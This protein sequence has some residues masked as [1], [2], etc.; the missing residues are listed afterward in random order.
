MSL[1]RLH[2]ISRSFGRVPVLRKVF[3]R[4]SKGDRVGLIGK[5]GVG[6]TTLLRLILGQD[7]PDGGTVDI[8]KGLTI[9]YFSQFSELSDSAT[10][11]DILEGLFSDIHLIKEEL[12]TIEKALSDAPAEKQIGGLLKRQ[13]SLFETMER[14]EGWTYRNRIDTVLT[15]LGFSAA[16]RIKPVGQLSGGWRNRAALAKILLEAPDILLM[17]EPTNFLDTDGLAWLEKWL[18][19]IP[20]ALIVVSH[21]R[22]FLDNV[23]GRIIEIENHQFQEYKGNF[24]QYIREKKLRLKTLGRQ[25]VFEKEL[26]IFEEAAIA[27]RREA[28]QN[29]D[30]ALKRKLANVKKQIEPKPSDRIITTI[31]D[32]L[33]VANKLCTVDNISKSH[34]GQT[35]FESLSFMIHRGDR[36][37]VIGP[38]GCGK[39]TL[40]RVLTE[41]HTPDTGS[42]TWHRGDGYAYYNRILDTLDLDDT[43]T[44]AVNVPGLG[45]R[46]P[47]KHVNR[48]LS[49]F[50]FSEMDLKQRIGALSGGQCARVALAISLLSGAG[51]IILDEPTNHLDITS[52]QVM[53]RALI[54]FPGAVLVVSHDRFFIDK[55][56]TRL[57]VFTD[58]GKVEEVSGNWTMWQASMETAD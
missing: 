51:V 47:R 10:I 34:P 17:D 57:L 42:V 8:D 24:T 45:Y 49:L 21:D 40:I 35:I 32:R 37:A 2:N 14:L 28:A 30:K 43:V 39:T 4:L 36:I 16:D 23:V 13:S 25:F 11:S 54:N 1:V 20:G 38:N 31:Y 56:A 3:F 46:A 55:V 53:E 27:S 58:P 33:Q 22:H 15:K 29:P 26:L 18:K 9:G 50:Q 44:H 6:K 48:F 5:N 12:S 19:Q 41:D 52:T 7:D